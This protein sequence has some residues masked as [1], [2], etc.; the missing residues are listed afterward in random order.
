M[1]MKDYDIN[2]KEKRTNGYLIATLFISFTVPSSPFSKPPVNKKRT[3]TLSRKESGSSTNCMVDG[4]GP[5]SYT[6]LLDGRV[7]PGRRRDQPCGSA[8]A[9]RAAA[10][11]KEKHLRLY[12]CRSGS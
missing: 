1:D 3:R 4:T 10:A 7:Q 8:S 2:F 12:L 6:H 5:V 11:G 9:R